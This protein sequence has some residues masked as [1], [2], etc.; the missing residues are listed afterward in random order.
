M[1]KHELS[2]RAKAIPRNNV[3]GAG[4]IQPDAPMACAG[5]VREL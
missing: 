4:Q 2:T 3:P 1:R 5:D